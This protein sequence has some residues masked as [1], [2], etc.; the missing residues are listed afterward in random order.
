M[1]TIMIILTLMCGICTAACSLDHF[2]I[3]HNQDGITGTADDNQLFV[4]CTQKYRHSDPDNQTT[5]TWKNWYYPLYPNMY[6]SYSVGEPGFDVIAS[7]DP[8]RKLSGTAN[9]DYRII[10]KCVAITSGFSAR[11]TTLGI[12]IDEAGESFNHSALADS[13]LHIEYRAPASTGGT[14]LQWIT[15]IVYDELETYEPSEPF[16]IVFGT[17][18]L[19]G[20][21]VIDGKV[22]LNDVAE[23]SYYW[24]EENGSIANDFYERADANKDS[25]VNFMDFALMAENYFQ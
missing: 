11:K 24:L 18:P 21:L 3:G 23:L 15:F 7:S 2:L 10:V 1:K 9:V 14:Q 16:S 19:A 6:G 22:D 12:L 25:K 13:H 8:D 17:D 4:D 20:D 5:D